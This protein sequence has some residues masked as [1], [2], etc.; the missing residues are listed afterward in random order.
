MATVE[1]FA[2]ITE[3][4]PPAMAARRPGLYSATT[5]WQ[6][7]LAIAVLP[8][9][10]ISPNIGLLARAVVQT[11]IIWSA[12][13]DSLTP[14]LLTSLSWQS[15][16][17]AS[18]RGMYTDS[19]TGLEG[20]AYI[21]GVSLMILRYMVFRGAYPQLPGKPLIDRRFA[22]LVLLIVFTLIAAYR[23]AVAGER[24][25][26][27]PFR[28]TLTAG[29]FFY[30]V[31]LAHTYG[32]SVK[33]LSGF[34]LPAGLIFYGL[35]SLGYLDHRLI[36]TLAPFV[37]AAATYILVTRPFSPAGVVAAVTFAISCW[38]CVL[39]PWSTGTLLLLWISGALTAIFATRQVLGIGRILRRP[40]VVIV[41][42][43]MIMTTAYVTLN[44]D[45][46]E[47]EEVTREQSLSKYMWWKMVEDRGLI[48]SQAMTAFASRPVADILFVPGGQSIEML[49]K[50]RAYNVKIG[51]HNAY[52]E[53][54]YYMGL[55]PGGVLCCFIFL[56]CWDCLKALG[57][58]M[59]AD[60]EIMAFGVLITAIV[61]GFSGQY[62]IHQEGG[63]WFYLPAGIVSGF[64]LRHRAQANRPAL[65]P[66]PL[67]A[68]G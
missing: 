34:F 20:Y 30:G 32:P 31:I 48:W 7:F 61:G 29:G 52:L 22:V 10:V 36:W 26:S 28:A 59:P 4:P 46:M 50:G 43:A 41:A 14:L 66:H 9:H 49:Y 51:L 63:T 44:K 47:A 62:F 37:S 27:S 58:K 12:R 68:A 64:Y 55:V 40:L 17:G 5:I 65:L 33:L 53:V 19:A 57:E 38:R 2:A 23:G 15:F 6:S 39:G 60:I 8:L 45:T 25:W 18:V 54:L 3:H 16:Q 21:F 1:I 24:G 13:F 11:P 56:F 42:T 67:S 35:S